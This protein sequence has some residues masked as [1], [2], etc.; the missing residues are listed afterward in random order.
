MSTSNGLFL[1]LLVAPSLISPAAS[2]SESEER[3]QKLPDQPF[4]ALVESPAPSDADD[5]PD[6]PGRSDHV[7]NFSWQKTTL[8]STPE[9]SPRYFSLAIALARQ[10]DSLAADYHLPLSEQ[11]PYFT[12]SFGAFYATRALNDIRYFT[13]GP[14]L[15]FEARYSFLRYFEPFLNGGIAFQHWKSQSDNSEVVEQNGATSALIGNYGMRLNF[16][17]YFSLIAEKA[18]T[19]YPPDARP[20]EITDAQPLPAHMAATQVLF[21]FNLLH[22]GTL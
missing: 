12:Y 14:R 15:K 13:Y 8:T 21:A 18:H 11:N 20:E 17:R 9:L 10:N 2:S 16:N 3:T 1:F 22:A 19:L 7:S 4:S 6:L 5:K